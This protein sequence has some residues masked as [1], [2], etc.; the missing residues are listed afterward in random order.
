MESSFESSRHSSTIG[1]IGVQVAHLREHLRVG[2]VPR[3]A[4]PA[5]RQLEPLEQ[6]LAELLGRAE[7]ERPAGQL[8]GLLLERLDLLGHPRGD[9]A[10][11]R[12]VDRDARALHRAEHGHERQLDVLQQRAELALGDARRQRLVQQQAARGAARE[13]R[14]ALAVAAGDGQAL[15]G[16]QVV[17]VVLAAARVD[18]VRGQ[19]GVEGRHDTGLGRAP[20]R[21][22]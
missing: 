18:Q 16:Q 7:H 9:L 20:R 6:H 11:A 12:R 14:V 2:R 5:R 10:H 15:L 3:L 21:T 8:V 17:E 13:H 4:A 22:P 19:L 1:T